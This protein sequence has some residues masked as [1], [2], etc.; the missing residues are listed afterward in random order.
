MTKPRHA[1]KIGTLLAD[2]LTR[3][4]LIREMAE[5]EMELGTEISAGQLDI[6]I[7]DL[8]RDAEEAYRLAGKVDATDQDE[9][10]AWV[11]DSVKELEQRDPSLAEAFVTD[12]AA[13]VGLDRMGRK[14]AEVSK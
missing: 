8:Y 9:I 1:E 6:V 10:R 14:V 12:L 4:E 2:I 7:R 13:A 11:L 5:S 3:A